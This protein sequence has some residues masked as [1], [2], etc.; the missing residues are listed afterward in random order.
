MASELIF[1]I[2][3]SKEQYLLYYQGAAKYVV[4][5]AF[6]GRTIQFPAGLLRRFLTHDGIHG[7]FRMTHDAQNRFKDIQRLD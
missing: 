2:E 3:L 6:D 4:T 7:V 5:Y 1:R